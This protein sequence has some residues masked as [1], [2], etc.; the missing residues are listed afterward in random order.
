LNQCTEGTG[1]HV[2]SP[3]HKAKHE[4]A[5]TLAGPD[6]RNGNPQRGI[7]RS[8]RCTREP[9][10]QR[11]LEESYLRIGA[12]PARLPLTVSTSLSNSNA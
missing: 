6:S 10:F 7:D 3:V 1:D 4:V 12:V 5:R 9:S 11:G 2:E 8:E